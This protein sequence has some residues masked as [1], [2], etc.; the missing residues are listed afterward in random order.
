MKGI[1]VG[2]G[3]CR[4]RE[5]EGGGRENKGAGEYGGTWEEEEETKEEE[6]KTK[7]RKE[8]KRNGS[9]NKHLDMTSISQSMV[10]V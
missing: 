3:T 8:K 2:E 4:G 9:I 5:N 6:G 10:E 7:E 1:G